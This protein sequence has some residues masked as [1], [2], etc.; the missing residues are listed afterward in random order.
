[1]STT[2]AIITAAGEAFEVGWVV[3]ED[4]GRPQLLLV[5]AGWLGA[6]HTDWAETWPC[7]TRRA[8]L[9]VI[10]DGAR[11]QGEVSA[12][13]QVVE[14]IQRRIRLRGGGSRDTEEARC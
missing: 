6:R 13:V 7:G 11:S 12:R 9:L 14:L 2:A 3:G 5:G 10:V 4:G 1:M 8:A